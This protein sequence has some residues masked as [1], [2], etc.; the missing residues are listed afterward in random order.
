MNPKKL[1]ALPAVVV[2]IALLL[3]GC[4]GGGTEAPAD[5]EQTLTIGTALENDTFDPAQLTGGVKDHYWQ[6]VYDTPLLRNVDTGELEP[7]LATEWSYDE[8]GT[9]L[10]L[11]LRDDVSFTDGTP[12]TAEAV[13]QN[14]LILRDA[15]A[16]SSFM[17]ADLVDAVAL[18]DHTVEY[19]LSQPNPAFL[20]YLAT[21]GGAIGNPAKIG[22]PE[23]ATEPAG[24]GPYIYDADASTP[25]TTYVFTRNE[26]YWNPD[27]YPYDTIV[28][29]VYVETAA[30]VNALKSGQIQGALFDPSVVDELEASDLHLDRMSIDWQGL[31][32]VDRNGVKTPA[33]ADVRVRQAIAYAIDGDSILASVLNGEGVPTTQVFN[34]GDIGYVDEL[35]DRYPFDPDKAR[36]LLAEAGYADGFELEIPQFDFASAAQPVIVQQLGEVGIQVKIAPIAPQDYLATVKGPNYSAFFMNLTS[37]DPWRNASKLFPVGATWNSFSVQDDTLDQL[38][39]DAALASAN[40]PEG[41]ADYMAQISEYA[42]DNVLMVPLFRPNMIYATDGSFTAKYNPYST[43]PELKDIVPAE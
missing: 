22:T 27:A 31:F 34:P 13:A 3:A 42:V 29:N 28:M 1:L 39:H 12:L 26:D 35:D 30:R 8:S 16:S 23:I 38:M 4:G 18:D 43:L 11:K 25:G 7:N 32:I 5:A 15:E 10:T 19:T 37:G 2:T 9:V 41:Y 21:I 6:A 33:I 14:A 36:E 24:S 20:G 40:D 17:M